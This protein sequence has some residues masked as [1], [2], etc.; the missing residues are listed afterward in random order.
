MLKSAMSLDGKIATHT[1][2]SKWISNEAS[3]KTVHEYRHQYAAILTGV[4][5]VIT[6]DS[7]LNTRLKINNPS[8]PIRI[9]LDPTGK[10]P[11]NSK[12]LNSPEFGKVIIA[13]NT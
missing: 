8:H 10:T 6:D 1:G 5:S 9:I 2:E 12:I 4:N 3:R 13:N 7:L 11:L